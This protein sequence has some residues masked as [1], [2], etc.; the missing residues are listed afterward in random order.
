MPTIS[1]HS[2]DKHDALELIDTP[3]GQTLRLRFAGPFEGGVTRWDATLYTPDAWATAR[4]EGK[5]ERNI[6]EIGAAGVDGIRLNICLQVKSIDLPTVRK[7]VIMI[8]RY[9]RLQRGRHEYG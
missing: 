1:S 4:G 3:G 5:T 7:A 2:H 6:I 9:K 8:R